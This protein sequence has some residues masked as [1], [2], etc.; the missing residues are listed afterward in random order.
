MIFLFDAVCLL[1]VAGGLAVAF[2][3]ASP[4]GNDPGTYARR[5]GGVMVAAFGLALGTIVTAFHF[6]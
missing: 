4:T 3:G 5:I 6:A 2:V 1:F